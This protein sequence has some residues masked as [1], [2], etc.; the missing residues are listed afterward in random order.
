[1]S[2]VN[3][4]LA[5]LAVIVVFA[6]VDFDDF[7]F[8][9]EQPIEF[10][11]PFQYNALGN[12]RSNLNGEMLNLENRSDEAIDLSGWTLESTDGR[13]Y[14]FPEGFALE[15]GARVTLHSGCGDDTE[16]DL[17][18]CSR[19]PIWDDKRGVATLRTPEYEWVAVYSYDIACTTCEI[20]RRDD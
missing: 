14:V 19:E 15:S 9:K 17:Y 11:E 13:T 6:V 18:W 2:A 10:V 3:I 4:G 20:K 7:T 5:L 12:D 8:S 1:M 16:S